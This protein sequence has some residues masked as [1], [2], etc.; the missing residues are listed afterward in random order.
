MGPSSP[1][2][3]AFLVRTHSLHAL[4]LSRLPESSQ[5][6]MFQMPELAGQGGAALAD[7]R[8][9]IRS[10]H[11]DNCRPIKI[12]HELIKDHES[13][14]T[15]LWCPPKMQDKQSLGQAP[16]MTWNWAT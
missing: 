3:L 14:I 9:E 7:S 4:E 5:L 13:G 12:V 10:V 15:A 8:E 16:S 2:S 11:P 6:M 1:W